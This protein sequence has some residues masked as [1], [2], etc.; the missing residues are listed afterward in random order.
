MV[1]VG[2]GAAVGVAVGAGVGVA[3]GAEVVAAGAAVG[4]AVAGA[5]VVGAAVVGAGVGVV[6]GVS[7][8]QAVRTTSTSAATADEVRTRAYMEKPFGKSGRM[9]GV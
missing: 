7:P 8:K 6:A 3:V 1:A 9:G 4:A 2:V 5:A